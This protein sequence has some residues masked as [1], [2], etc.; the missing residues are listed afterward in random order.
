M[1]TNKTAFRNSSRLDWT[2]VP[3]P[4]IHTNISDLFCI[5]Y[6]SLCLIEDLLNEAYQYVITARLQNDPVED[7]LPSTGEWMAVV[8]LS[9]CDKSKIQRGCCNTVLYLK[10]ILT[11]GKTILQLRSVLL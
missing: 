10:K 11:S 4:G 1:G 6:Y 3:V 2:M 9:I 8:F 5:D 7:V